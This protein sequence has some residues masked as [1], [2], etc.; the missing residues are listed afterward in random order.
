MRAQGD[1]MKK[2]TGLFLALLC[3][4]QVAAAKDMSVREIQLMVLELQKTKYVMEFKPE[5]REALVNPS[6]WSTMTLQNKQT[7]SML[8]A[9]YCEAYRHNLTQQDMV[10]VG[11]GWVEIMDGYTGKRL[12][13]YGVWGFKID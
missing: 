2:I 6:M 9:M 1:P 10:K 11:D 7:T 3:F 4:A 5:L 12:A 13:K 8:L